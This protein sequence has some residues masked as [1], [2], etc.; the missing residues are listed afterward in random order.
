MELMRH[1]PLASGKGMGSSLQ[2]KEHSSALVFLAS[3][4]NQIVEVDV[5]DSWRH[6]DSHL[7]YRRVIR[8]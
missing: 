7:E 6:S 5:A 1:S 4:A 3:A 2:A 8:P